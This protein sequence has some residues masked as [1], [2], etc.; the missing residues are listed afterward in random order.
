MRV[1]NFKQ[2][3][4]VTVFDSENYSY[5]TST[6]KKGFIYKICQLW[7]TRK[8]INFFKTIPLYTSLK[9]TWNSLGLLH[10]Y[11][12]K[13]EI[14]NL[15][16]CLF[17]LLGCI[18]MS[19]T[20][21]QWHFLILRTFYIQPPLSQLSVCIKYIK[22]DGQ[23]RVYTFSLLNLYTCLWNEHEIVSDYYINSW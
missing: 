5:V 4:A 10:K 16:L 14:Y 21:L 11:F 19:S 2:G 3:F 8:S 7:W 15:M 20:I 17:F 1:Y 9:W 12:V 6:K 22:Y 18:Y 23:G 13:M